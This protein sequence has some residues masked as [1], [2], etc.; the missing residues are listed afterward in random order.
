MKKESVFIRPGYQK[1]PSDLKTYNLENLVD[2]KELAKTLDAT[3]RIKQTNT[4]L[5][6]DLEHKVIHQL[7]TSYES[8]GPESMQGWL[9]SD[10]WLTGLP[11]QYVRFRESSQDLTVFL[12]GDNVFLEKG[13]RGQSPVPVAKDSVRFDIEELQNLWFKRDYKTLLKEQAKKSNLDIEEAELIYG[14]INLPTYG[15]PLKPDQFV[16]HEQLGLTKEAKEN[17]C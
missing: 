16:H 3:N 14:E 7:L 2:V 6:A 13:D 1:Q 15:K 17:L 9:D 8:K 4:S 5:L 10:W 12:T 11:Q